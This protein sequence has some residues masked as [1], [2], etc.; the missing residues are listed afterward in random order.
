MTMTGWRCGMAAGWRLADIGLTRSRSGQTMDMVWRL[1]GS[2]IATGRG[3]DGV[4]GC[5]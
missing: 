1:G 4:I 5:L 3:D 2:E